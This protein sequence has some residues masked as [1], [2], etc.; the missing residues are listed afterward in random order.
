MKL[1]LKRLNDRALL[2]YR[3]YPDDAGLD[4]F[5]MDDIILLPGEFKD[6]DTGWAV[7]IHDGFWGSVKARSSTFFKRGLIV[8]EG[9]IDSGY[10][11][12]LSIGVY[13]PNNSLINLHTG[14]RIA[15]LVIMPLFTPTVC[16]VNE[17]PKTSRGEGGFGSTGIGR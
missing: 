12:K 13:N 1:L 4:L 2:P 11:G 6:I 8:H 5:I 3:A 7:K 16:V 15:Q 14:D 10:T 17:L 9:T